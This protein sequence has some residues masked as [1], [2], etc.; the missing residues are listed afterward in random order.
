MSLLNESHDPTLMS[1][2]AQANQPGSDF[3]IQNLPLGRYRHIGADEDFKIGV[4]IG[5]QTVNLQG[6]GLIDSPDMNALI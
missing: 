3:P 1:W 6:K 2:V 5:D 4:A